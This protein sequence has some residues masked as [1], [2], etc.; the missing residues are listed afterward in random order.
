MFKRILCLLLSGSIILSNPVSGYCDDMSTSS[1][2][3]MG[4]SVIGGIPIGGTTKYSF[5]ASDAEAYAVCYSSNHTPEIYGSFEIWCTAYVVDGY[6]APPVQRKTVN[7]D[8][9]GVHSENF[10]F[11]G[12]K[13]GEYYCWP[14]TLQATISMNVY[15]GTTGLYNWGYFTN[16]NGYEYGGYDNDADYS[17]NYNDM[18]NDYSL[19]N[20]YD[21]YNGNNYNGNYDGSYNGSYDGN[22]NGNANG[23]YNRNYNGY[24]YDGSY[25]GNSNDSYNG[26]YNSTSYNGSYDSNHNNNA[27]GSYNGNYNGNNYNDSY[28]GNYNGSHNGNYNGNYG[29]NNYFNNG[30]NTN[31][32]SDAVYDGDI[33]SADFSIDDFAPEMSDTDDYFGSSTDNLSDYKM[34]GLETTDLV[35]GV[36][37][38]GEGMDEKTANEMVVN[39]FGN[40]RQPDNV[41][42]EDEFFASMLAFLNETKNQ[43]FNNGYVEYDADGN[44]IY[45]D[46][47]GNIIG[48]SNNSTNNI[49]ENILENFIDTSFLDNFKAPQTISDQEMFN[50]ARKILKEL[51]YSLEDLMKNK[52][53]D[54]GSAYTDPD[55]A[56]DMNRITTLLKGKK[57]KLSENDLKQLNQI[58]ETKKK[59]AL[60]QAIGN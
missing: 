42:T 38:I 6:F 40:I 14:V 24:N 47:D 33:S 60:S 51:G 17:Y 20:N 4:A 59:S 28:N 54:D 5:V 3:E 26:T 13:C 30:Y 18:P 45:Y 25:N 1:V 41:E 55:R 27:D 16:F 52:T 15:E 44:P 57:I 8:Y 2:V 37:Y 56:W 29:N 9:S 58:Q 35:G 12:I 11:A 23:S 46:K 10:S 43:S 36:K 19:I 22:Y 50:I 21:A 48:K 7:Y 39:A 53:Y 34:Y 49:V 32:Y 31:S